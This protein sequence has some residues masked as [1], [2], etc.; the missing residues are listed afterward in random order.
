LKAK[1]D[2]VQ[3]QQVL[4]NLI[5]NAADA[6]RAATY[7]NRRILIRAAQRPDDT[8]ELIV[9][10]RGDG[11][12]EDQL[13]KVFEPFYTTK[14]EGLGMGLSICRTLVESHGGR[15]WASNNPEGGASLHVILP[16][17]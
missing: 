8:V 11:I 10:D 6:V 13:H 17:G 3:L 5:M 12:P 7:A 16:A 1:A 9:S 2:R 15:M 14:S 4:L